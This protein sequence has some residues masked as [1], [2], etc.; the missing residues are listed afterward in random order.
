MWLNKTLP[1]QMW[2]GLD[3]QVHPCAA[4]MFAASV[5]SVV[6]NCAH[7]LFWDDIWLEGNSLAEL[8]PNLFSSVPKRIIKRRKACQQSVG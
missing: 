4:A 8:G 3:I 5:R 2:A 1:D 7:T 6:G